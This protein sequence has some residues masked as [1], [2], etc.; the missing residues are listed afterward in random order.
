MSIWWTVSA[1]ACSAMPA[2][3]ESRERR[4]RGVVGRRV[5]PGPAILAAA[6]A[7]LAALLLP[8]GGPRPLHAQAVQSI[9]SGTFEIRVNGQ[10]AG[11]ETFAVRREG[12]VVKA[13]G[14]IV[15]EREGTSVR[16]MDVQLQTDAVFRP[17]AYALRARSGAVT[18]VDG[19]WEG[20][21]LRLHV[22]SVEGERWKEFLTRG[23]VAVLERGVAHHYYL[24][25]RQLPADPAGRAVSVIV[26]SRNEQVEARVTGGAAEPVEVGGEPVESRRWEV[27]AEGIRRTVW[28]AGDGRVLRVSFPEEGRVAVRMADR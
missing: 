24:L 25:F 12:N 21:R 13:V 11:T 5:A 4:E 28:L 8:T 15:A 1:R 9:D 14:R 23:P 17:T 27:E 19:F 3:R 20:D 26:P 10:R 18:G 7:P 22:S 6:L 2:G 16:N